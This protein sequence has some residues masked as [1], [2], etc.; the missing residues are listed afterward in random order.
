M[1]VFLFILNL[2]ANV[3]PETIVNSIYYRNKISLNGTWKYCIEQVNYC[4][5]DV[6]K[7]K[8]IRE[9]YKSKNKFERIEFGFSNSN[10]LF[11]PCDWNMQ[12]EKLFYYEGVIWYIKKFPFNKKHDQKIMMNFE[13]VNYI[14]ES[15]F[16][17]AFLG[18]HEGGFTPFQFGLYKAFDQW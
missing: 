16:N 13:A 12:D 14:L 17:E 9:D 4:D 15:Y 2:K 5:E 18:S 3:S 1:I 7:G 8:S 6:A 11:V 10:T